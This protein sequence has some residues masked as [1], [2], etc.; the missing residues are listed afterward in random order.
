MS[1]RNPPVLELGR[2]KTLVF[3]CDGVILDS[4]RAKTE[5]FYRT[6]RPWGQ[7]AANRLVRYH[8]QNGGISRYA[9]FRFFN[10][11]V[12]KLNHPKTAKGILAK[13]LARYGQILRKK[14]RQCEITSGLKRLRRETPKAKWLVVTGGDQKEVRAVFRDRSL[15]AFFDGG[16]FG[17]PK[18]KDQIIQREI[19]A[20]NIRKPALY[21]GDSRYDHDVAKKTGLQFCFISQWSEVNNWKPWVKKNH[22]PTL[23]SLQELLIP[24][25]KNKSTKR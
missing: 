18:P 7:A 23:R 20:G 2:Y 1:V 9:K 24:P 8:R 4:N 17:S 14:L 3:D 5:A 21:F 12:L 19:L 10:S 22:I 6:T 13:N 16:I 11:S 25:P 15:A